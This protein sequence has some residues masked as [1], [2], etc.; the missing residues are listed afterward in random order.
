MAHIVP[1]PPNRDSANQSMQKFN[2][3]T[4]NG[5]ADIFAWGLPNNATEIE[6]TMALAR[7][8]PDHS[9][10][11]VVSMAQRPGPYANMRRFHLKGLRTGDE[12][13]IFRNSNFNKPFDINWVQHSAAVTVDQIFADHYGKALAA[14]TLPKYASNHNIELYPFGALQRTPPL[15]EQVWLQSVVKTLDTINA[16]AL[17]RAILGLVKSRVVIHPW[18]PPDMNAISDISFTPQTWDRTRSPGMRA[19]EVLL[20]EFIHILDNQCSGYTDAKGFQF[21]SMDF[22][23]VNATNVYSCLLGRSLRKDHH[24]WDFL[25]IEYITNPR[26]HFEDLR[27][28][29]DLAKSAAPQLYNVLKGGSDLWNPFTF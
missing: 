25:P 21:D 14:G 24:G 1:N 8:G 10:R 4:T 9:D 20:H 28:D 26:K 6:F 15:S 29:Y 18:V 19:D 3:L 16:N 11:I 27:A 5:E 23:T 17:G 12:I 22:L 7:S 2:I 13:A